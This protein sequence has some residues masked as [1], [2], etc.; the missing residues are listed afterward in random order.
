MQA[1][2]LLGGLG[3]R[4]G[5]LT[6]Y[7]PK[8]LIDIYGRPFLQYQLEWLASYGLNDVVFCV[9]HFAD[10][11]ESFAGDGHRMGVRI[12]YSREEGALLG[13]A[14]A[15]CHARHLLEDM[16]FVLNGD[17]YLPIDPRPPIESFARG[18]LTAMMLVLSNRDQYD[19][20]NVV[21]RD[22][23]V[24]AYDRHRK[25]P[26]MEFIDYGMQLFKKEVLDLI[27]EDR[28]V[29]LDV[30]YRRLI[31]EDRLAAFEVNETFYEIGSIGGLA[32]FKEYVASK[33][34]A[35]A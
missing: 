19:K 20:S 30:V 25:S 10:Q 13:T 12:R 21:A 18:R 16:F 28:F 2:I 3:T 5:A 9:G 29:D 34:L 24:V 1:V 33:G 8:A 27:P 11:I 32:R 23:R 4:L 26:S 7:I 31:A 35:R 14:G 6:K 17:S 22:G 15:L